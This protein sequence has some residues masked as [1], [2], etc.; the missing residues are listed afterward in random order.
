LNL[1]EAVG[2]L[3]LIGIPGKSLDSETIRLLEFVRPGFVILFARNV[4]NPAQVKGLL[5][6]INKLLPYKPVFAID[7]E[8]GMVSRLRS[9]FTVSPS[10]MALSATGDAGNARRA[11]E[12]LAQEMSAVGINWNLAPVVDINVNHRNPGI[13]VRSFGDNPEIVTEFAAAFIDGMNRHGIL[14][15]LKHFPGLG[16][17]DADPH[18]E[19]PVLDL[20]ADELLRFELVPFCRIRAESVMP[21]HIYLPKLQT[22]RGP[23]STAEEVLTGLARRKLGYEG[24]LVADDLLMN[25]VT[26]Y[27]TV[28]EGAVQAFRAGMDVLSLCH[29]PEI[30]H[31][32]KDAV[33]KAVASSPALQDRLVNSLGRIAKFRERALS[34]PLSS[35]DKVGSPE[36]MGEMERIFDSSVTAILGD[37]QML[38]LDTDLITAVY[39]VRLPR[40]SQG[41]GPAQKGIP[42]VA[43]VLAEK[44]RTAVLDFPVEMSTEEAVRLAAVAPEGG[45]V[46]V[47]TANAHLHAGQTALVEGLTRRAQSSLLIALL[48][49][50]D[51]FISGVENCLISYGYEAMAQQSLLKVLHGTIAPTGKLPVGRPREGVG[52][53]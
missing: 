24:V 42:W 25:G 16:R 48:S 43:Q 15:C 40:V 39:S 34:A 52:K 29:R 53:C 8:G 5:D 17:V 36:H 22:K 41:E 4:E 35:F 28:E 37:P 23:A 46:V 31:A 13:G 50:Y 1:S 7:Q 3:F 44:S 49:P 51:C 6:D 18:F 26:N 19:L 14:T 20:S 10:A 21:S 30:Q 47:V 38:P 2:Q 45:L 12:I 9:G 27:C 11:A 33:Q 32:T